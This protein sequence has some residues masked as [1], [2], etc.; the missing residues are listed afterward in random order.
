MNRND[1]KEF[2]LNILTVAPIIIPIIALF[3]NLHVP[4]VSCT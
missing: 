2:I 4:Y 3:D 1:C